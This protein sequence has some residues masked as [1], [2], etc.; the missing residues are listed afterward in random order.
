MIPV[1]VVFASEWFSNNELRSNYSMVE[2]L[3]CGKDVIDYVLHS[4]VCTKF[5]NG[6][7]DLIPFHAITFVQWT[8]VD[9]NASHATVLM[10][11]TWFVA[12]FV[13]VDEAIAELSVFPFGLERVWEGDP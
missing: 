6:R 10:S 11:A 5:E 8:T 2:E 9:V 13:H 7:E 3:R 1:L 12:S 4:R